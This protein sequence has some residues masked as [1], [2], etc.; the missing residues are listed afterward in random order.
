M[1]NKKIHI[2]R[3]GKCEC[4]REDPTA[5]TLDECEK[6]RVKASSVFLDS[7]SESDSGAKLDTRDFNRGPNAARGKPA[8]KA[9]RR[10]QYM[11]DER[12]KWLELKRGVKI[13]QHGKGKAIFAKNP[14][15]TVSAASGNQRKVYPAKRPSSGDAGY[16]STTSEEEDSEDDNP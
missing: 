7:D 1:D 6:K 12:D 10:E 3:K 2:R 11:E 8:T 16:D 9:Q 13:V 14:D 15:G 5:E 4:A